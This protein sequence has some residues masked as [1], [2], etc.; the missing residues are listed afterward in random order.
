MRMCSWIAIVSMCMSACFMRSKNS[1]RKNAKAIDAALKYLAKEQAENGSWG[2]GQ[3]KAASRHESLG[4]AFLAGNH[5]RI[6]AYGKSSRRRA[7]CAEPG[8]SNIAG[9][10]KEGTHGPMYGHLRGLVRC[11]AITQSKMR[12]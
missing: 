6:E 10:F 2:T 5:R 3:Y 9:F 4:L 1:S 12:S 7:A 11:D 8:R